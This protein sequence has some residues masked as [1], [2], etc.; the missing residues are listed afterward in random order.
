MADP[1][2]ALVKNLSANVGD[3]GDMTS[4]AG[5]GRPSEVS[6]GN[7]LQQSCLENSM[8]KGAWQATVREVAT[9]HTQLSTHMQVIS[10]HITDSL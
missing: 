1:G 7:W 4:I 8:G 10:I 9:S 6:N 5:S 3:T 2:G